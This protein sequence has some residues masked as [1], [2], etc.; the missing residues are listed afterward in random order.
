MV[1]FDDESLEIVEYLLKKPLTKHGYL[2]YNSDTEDRVNSNRSSWLTCLV[3]SNITDFRWHG[4]RHTYAT[5]EIKKGIPIYQLSK[6][7]GHSNVTIT[8]KYAYLYTEDLHEVKR[9]ASSKKPTMVGNNIPTENVISDTKVNT[10]V[11][12]KNNLDY[13]SVFGS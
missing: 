4:L 11:F 13:T 2:H 10:S 5:D 1:P 3:K 6:M 8:E 7:L 9:K 12:V